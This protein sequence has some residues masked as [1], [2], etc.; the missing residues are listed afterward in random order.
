MHTTHA[1]SAD[2]FKYRA[3]T[4]V[5]EGVGCFFPGFSLDDR[6]GII[7]PNVY[8]GVLG[9]GLG[10]LAAV[11]EFYKLRPS[12]PA[13]C[14]YPVY[15]CFLDAGNEP[16]QIERAWSN[17][18][19]WPATQW[20]L[21]TSVNDYAPLVLE[22]GITLLFMPESRVPALNTSRE[23]ADALRQSLRSVFLYGSA[24]PNVEIAASEEAL[25]LLKRSLPNPELASRVNSVERHRRLSREEFVRMLS[26]N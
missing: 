11:T 13:G 5:D 9:A 20:K 15:F 12:I 19:V 10:V 22:A 21:A 14:N 18:D 17:L 23:L 25:K 26:A 2:H 4:G 8:D 6:L 7:S 3:C 24:K 16:K 1:I